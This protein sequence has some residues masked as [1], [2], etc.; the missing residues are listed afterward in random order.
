[1]LLSICVEKLFTAIIYFSDE[2]HIIEKIELNHKKLK[3]TEFPLINE[4]FKSIFR[5]FVEYFNDTARKDN[6]YRYIDLSLYSTFCKSV[7]SETIK[8]PYGETITYAELARRVLKPEA[9]R[10]VG[11]CLSKNRYPLIIPCHRV[12]GMKDLGGFKYGSK[13][14]KVI[15]DREKSNYIS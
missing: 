2:K 14:K 1:M 11:Q 9:A 13:L 10:A 5:Y 7:Y 8:I 4:G 15:L 6:I 12:V 3:D